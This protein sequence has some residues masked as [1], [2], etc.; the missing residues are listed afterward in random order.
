MKTSMVAPPFRHNKSTE[1][2]PPVRV[3]FMIDTLKVGGVESQLL[4]LLRQLDRSRIQ[5]YLC[6]LDGC[7]EASRSL[8]PSDCPVLRLGV[9]SLHHPSSLLRALQLARFLRH[10]RIDVLQLFFADSTYF[11]APVGRI[12][13]VPVIVRSR[14]DIGFWVRPIDRWLGRICTWLVDA[15]LANCEA[16]RRSVVVDEGADPD[17]V[18]IIPNGVDLARFAK[19]QELKGDSISAG[20]ARVGVVANLSP[21]KAIDLL[22]RAAAI[23]V[24]HHPSIRF[25]VAGEGGLRAELDCLIRSLGLQDRFE[26]LGTVADIPAFLSTLDVAV[27]CSRTEGAPNAIVEYM[28]AG[29]P[30]VVT[31]VGGNRELIEDETHGLVVPPESASHLAAAIHRLLQDRSLAARLAGNA[32]R[33]GVAEHSAEVYARRY[34][35]FYRRCYEKNNLPD[36]EAEGGESTAF[37]LTAEG[38][39]TS[40]T[41]TSSTSRCPSVSSQVLQTTEKGSVEGLMLVERIAWVD[42]A[43]GVGIILVVLGHVLYGMRHAALPLPPHT[44]YVLDWIYCFHMPLFFFLSGM[45]VPPSILK[46]TGRFIRHR[47]ATILYCYLLWSLLDVAVRTIFGN[48]TN[49]HVGWSVL[50]HVYDQPLGELWFLYALFACNLGFILLHGIGVATPG[51]LIV[52]TAALVFR[53]TMAF[54]PQSILDLIL[55]HSFFFTIG[56]AATNLRFTRCR[57]LDIWIPLAL[58]CF[59]LMSGIVV[60]GNHYGHLQAPVAVLGIAGSILLGQVLAREPGGVH[61]RFLKYLGLLS[62]QIYLAHTLFEASWRILCQKGLGTQNMVGIIAGGLVAGIVGPVILQSLAVRVRFPYLFALPPHRG[63]GNHIHNNND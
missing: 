39:S 17:S 5:P 4:L 32:R 20:C 40:P 49:Y 27:L 61:W 45:F 38:G 2:K 43:K 62:L 25:Q 60:T 13:G 18:V 34:E 51:I 50:L 24:E 35:D 44:S 19:F 41:E 47:I 37:A 59:A 53:N 14:L 54:E 30:I 10:H 12:A 52:G 31:D 8:E 1:V 26:L 6:L 3:C 15:T 29:R 58:A 57:R 28:I 42:Y 22:V 46:G 16:C 36:S 21:W 11:G 7:G 23:L 55:Y 33:K 9:R 56:I 48:Y 63:W